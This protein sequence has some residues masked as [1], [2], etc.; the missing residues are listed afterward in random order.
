MKAAKRMVP[1]LLFISFALHGCALLV[2]GGLGAGAGAGVVAYVQGELKATYASPLN[3]T[4]EASL[5][6]LKDLNIMV[7]NTQKD[8]TGGTIEAMKSDGTRVRLTLKSEAPDVTSVGIRVGTFGDE[9][10]SKAIN[11]RMAMRLGKK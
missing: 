1:I 7:T 6:A 3:R 11:D 10:V 4:W 9:A 8:A 2:A 5:G